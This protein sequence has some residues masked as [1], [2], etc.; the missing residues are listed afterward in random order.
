MKKLYIVKKQSSRIMMNPI[1]IGN[2][3]RKTVQWDAF[4]KLG[5]GYTY[6]DCDEDCSREIYSTLPEAQKSLAEKRSTLDMNTYHG[7]VYA[8]LTE[9]NLETVSLDDNGQEYEWEYIDSTEF[10]IFK[11]YVYVEEREENKIF[12]LYEGNN[13]KE[14]C[15]T[16]DGCDG[17]IYGYDIQDF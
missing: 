14:A 10:P 7:R 16:L 2:K 13:P 9:Y 12:Y 4:L 8:D 15:F 6:Q 11:I 1:K 17:K 3:W 5:K